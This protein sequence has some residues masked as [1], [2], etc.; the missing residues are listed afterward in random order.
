VRRDGA[1]LAEGS[2]LSAPRDDPEGLFGT[3]EGLCADVLAAAGVGVEG[4][5]A[6]GVGAVGPMEYP[7]GVLASLNIPAWR[8]GF[9]LRARLEQHLGRP[10]VVDND[11]KAL[12][13]GEYWQGAGQGARCLLGMVVSTGVGGGLVLGG[14]LVHGATGNAGHVGHLVVWRGGPRCGCGARGC[15]EAIASGTGIARRARLAIARG[16]PTMLRG[17][18]S[19]AEVAE[20]ARAGDP[21]ARRLF[22]DAGAALGIGIASAAALLDADRVV[23]AGGV[24]TG[25][26]ALLWDPLRQVLARA[27]CLDFT[28]GLAVL[29]STLGPRASLVGAAAL[30]FL[31]HNSG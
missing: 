21:L 15:V 22:R 6:I 8:H 9:P 2:R 5:W 30:V 26:G 28:R 11:A 27:A 1:L 25:S 17:A 23:I 20:A 3:L 18:P 24:A 14:R 29:P 19:A 16:V 10:V 31:G 12:A 13:L 4:I 7:A